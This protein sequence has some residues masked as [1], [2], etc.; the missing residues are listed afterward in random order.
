MTQK[1]C[2]N[3]ERSSDVIPLLTLEYQGQNYFICP[4]CMPTLIHKPHALAGK[5]PGSENLSP[6]DHAH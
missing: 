1:I 4:Q 2:L 5:L 3:C 6:S